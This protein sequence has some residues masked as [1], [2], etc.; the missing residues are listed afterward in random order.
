MNIENVLI[1][2]SIMWK[3]MAGIFL[4][5]IIVML[6]VMLMSKITAKSPTKEQELKKE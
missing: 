1:A 2:L 3:G 5:I 4:V 6:L